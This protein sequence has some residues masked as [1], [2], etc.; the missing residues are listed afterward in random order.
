M[1]RTK[2]GCN[3]QGTRKTKN[4]FINVCTVNASYEKRHSQKRMNNLF[5]SLKTYNY[6]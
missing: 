2:L 4:Q 5:I 6:L 3:K 1:S